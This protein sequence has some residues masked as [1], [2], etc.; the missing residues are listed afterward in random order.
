LS[1]N[2]TIILGVTGGIAAYKSVEIVRLFQKEK[3]DTHVV[4]T[5]NATQFISPLT[6]QTISGNPLYFELFS[7][8]DSVEALHISLAKKAQLLLIAP[9]SANIISKFAS[10]LADDLLSTLFLAF[11]GLVIIAPS[12]NEAM[13]NHPILQ[14]N[15]KKLRE[16]G[17]IIIEPEEGA[18]AC[19]SEG[20]GRLAS[21]DKIVSFCLDIFFKKKTLKGEKFLITA[22]PTREFIDPVRFI[23]NRSSGKMGYTIAQAARKRGAEVIL[24]SGPTQLSCPSDIDIK[25]VATAE[26]MKKQVLSFYEQSSVIIMAAAVSDYRPF[27]VS[28]KKIKK[29]HEEWN[30]RLKPT[31]DILTEISRKSKRKLLIGFA[32]ESDNILE[33]ARKKLKAKRLHLMVVNDIYLTNSGFESDYNTVSLLDK[34]GEEKNLPRLLK[35][36]VAEIIIDKIEELLKREKL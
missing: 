13:Y 14:K 7:E 17:I 10:G 26:E 33:N 6:L 12:M 20:K 23:T 2:K 8:A 1:Q 16:L 25:K 30:L 15:L 36:Q 4:M 28:K 31:D 21:P 24:I 18:L 9:A 27:R 5:H 11:K 3:V 19:G 32:A 34:H 35:A 29:K 22:G